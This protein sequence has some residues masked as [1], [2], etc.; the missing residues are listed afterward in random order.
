MRLAQLRQADLNLLVV[1]AVLAEERSVSR[2]ASRLSLSQP[3]VSR[4]LQRL[5]DM[6]RDD[7]LIRTS[8][9][10]EPTPKGQRM[11]SELSAILP[12]LDRM[13][14]GA[15]FDPLEES[16]T[17]RIAVT[18]NAAQVVCPNLCRAVLAK[19]KRVTF[20]FIA[21][22][23]G[24]IE[25]VEHGRLD[26]ALNADDG[27]APERF[28]REVIYEDEF[29]CIVSKESPYQKRI[30]LKQYAAGVHIGIGTLAGRQTVPEQRLLALGYQRTCVL[31]VPYFVA[32]MRCIPG[33]DLIATVPKRLMAGEPSDPRIRVLEPPPELTGFRYLMLWHPRV[34]TDAAHAWLRGAI[35][36]ASRKGVVA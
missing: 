28:Q 32:A 5:R 19:A 27:H 10:Y 3:A 7:L 23:D 22:H 34:H 25:E 21:W 36:D 1:F 20:Q 16:A 6:F 24:S 11:L 14:A 15:D 13:L 35:R 33:T 17:F 8:D 9:G 2:S 31:E 26:L 18:D 4:A 30:S 29:V 12:R